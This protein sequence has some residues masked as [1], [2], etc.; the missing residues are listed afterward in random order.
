MI[1]ARNAAILAAALASCLAPAAANAPTQ[2]GIAAALLNRVT[3]ARG[4]A[5]PRIERAVAIRNQRIIPAGFCVTRED[6][7]GVSNG[8]HLW[9]CLMCH[10]DCSPSLPYVSLSGQ[11]AR[12]AQP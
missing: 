11:A 3:I 8:C 1:R 7:T 9:K 6:Q 10:A 5:A 12:A 2:V 4:G